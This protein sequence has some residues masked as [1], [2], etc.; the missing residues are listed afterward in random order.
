MRREAILCRYHHEKEN[1]TLR[2][3]PGKLMAAL[4]QARHTT[5]VSPLR[6]GG[7]CLHGSGLTVTAVSF[8][9][10]LTRQHD[11]PGYVPER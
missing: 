9:H 2:A 4:I 5:S 3:K 8:L 11:R 1:A 7:R 10:P 6:S